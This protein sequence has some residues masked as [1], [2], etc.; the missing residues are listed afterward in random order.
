MM[1]I[2]KE[3]R[4]TLFFE[5]LP[6]VNLTRAEMTTIIEKMKIENVVFASE[7]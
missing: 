5:T 7:K 2:K 6:E 3:R 4:K 1:K